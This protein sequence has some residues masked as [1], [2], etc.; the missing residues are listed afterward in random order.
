M[1]QE[2]DTQMTLKKQRNKNAYIPVVEGTAEDTGFKGFD[3]CDEMCNHCMGETFNIPADRVSLCVH[4]GA[5]LFPCAVCEDG[6]DWSNEKSDCHRF[7]RVSQLRFKHKKKKG[8]P[9]NA[10]NPQ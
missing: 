5:E 2:Q 1:N 3:Y 6:C 7:K 8:T 10:A 4:C 9:K